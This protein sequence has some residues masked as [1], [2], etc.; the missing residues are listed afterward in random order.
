MSRAWLEAAGG[1]IGL[2][3]ILGLIYVMT[4]RPIVERRRRLTDIK[5]G[6]RKSG[7]TLYPEMRF[8]QDSKE[9]KFVYGELVRKFQI[10]ECELGWFFYESIPA[11]KERIIVEAANFNDR[12]AA[13]YE[14][15][16]SYYVALGYEERPS[17]DELPQEELKSH[18]RW[19][20]P[21]TWSRRPEEAGA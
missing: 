2:L 20:R 7:Y 12:I 6:L 9:V 13:L 18:L 8:D 14:G 17:H 19:L 15:E 11:R 10:D 21:W 16:D 1:V 4:I 5:H 3:L